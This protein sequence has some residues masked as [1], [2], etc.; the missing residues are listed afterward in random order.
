VVQVILNPSIVMA[1]RDCGVRGDVY[2]RL[3]QIGFQLVG[4]G[5]V[6]VHPTISMT[7]EAGAGN[8]H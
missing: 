2:G 6:H 1:E 3:G 7:V 4:L 5:P 8:L